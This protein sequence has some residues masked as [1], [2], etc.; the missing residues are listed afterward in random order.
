MSFAARKFLSLLFSG[1]ICSAVWF[2]SETTT[3]ALTGNLLGESALAGLSLVEPFTAA[4]FFVTEW[5]A[6]GTEI[7]FSNLMGSSD[8]RKAKE[9]FTV[10][11]IMELTVGVLF[12]LIP[13]FATDSYISFF[14]AGGEASAFAAEYLKWFLPAPI[15]IALMTLSMHMVMAEGDTM[16]CTAAGI[17]FL[18]FDAVLTFVGL[19]LGFGIASAAVAVSL[20]LT[21]ALV[22]QLTH[23]F[24]RANT[25]KIVRP[26]SFE[27]V[28]RIP[29]ASF[30]DSA[31]KLSKALFVVLLTKTAVARFGGEFLPVMQ[32][33]ITLWG[34]VDILDGI[35][36]AIPSLVSVYHAEKNPAGVRRVMSIASKLSLF[37]A[38]A[39][40]VF[41]MICPTVLTGLLGITDIRL[42]TAAT[43]AVRVIAPVLI[44]LSLS[45][46]YSAYFA[47]IGHGEYSLFI[48]LGI[49]LLG[50]VAAIAAF[51]AMGAVGIWLGI[52][53][54]PIVAFAA[55]SFIIIRRYGRKAFPLLLDREIEALTTSF[56]LE[57]TDEAVVAVSQRIGGKLSGTLSAR[58]SLLVEEVLLA[59]RDRNRPKKVLAE[60][61]L[62]E[63][64]IPRLICRDDGVIFD[65]TDTDQRVSSL[66]SFVVANLMERETGRENLVMTGFNRNVFRLA[67]A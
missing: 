62:I 18:V 47:C 60:V 32:V 34:M 39:I 46:L 6:F 24:S 41:L 19:K 49:F 55:L 29:P 50:P 4:I 65:I 3:V 37:V 28:K 10:G 66:R 63:G 15:L 12:S 56:S 31:Q 8:E 58:T 38:S 59:V 26:K 40:V 52:L 16:R 61:S 36:S 42:V 5:I 30:G 20:A 27:F 35:A 33:V 9:A 64:E 21:A 7:V 43:I 44:V 14:A 11:L 67:C 23:L 2:L 13:V 1:V 45:T 25:L 17:V 54:G 53:L 51:S 57:L 48:S 22:V